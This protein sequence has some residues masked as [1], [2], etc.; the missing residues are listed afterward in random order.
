MATIATRITSSGTYFINGSFDEV[1][2]NRTSPVIKNL[3]ISTED[4]SQWANVGHVITTNQ[5]IAPDGSLTADRIQATTGSGGDY[6]AILNNSSVG[7]ASYT[8]SFWVKSVSGA[9]GTWGVNYY[10]GAHNRTTVP[11][12][13]EWT[14]QS[15]TFT[16]TGG[17]FNVYIADNRT[18][19]ATITDAYV[20]GAQLERGTVPTIYQGITSSG[21]LITPTFKNKVTSDAVY[22]TDIFDEVTFNPAT[23]G[24]Y[25]G[26]SLSYSQDMSQTSVWSYSSGGS[27]VPPVVTPN[28]ALAPDGTLTANRV[29]FNSGPVTGTGQSSLNQG[30]A[31]PLTT[32]TSQTF[33]VWMRVETTATLVNMYN[34]D[35]INSLSIDTNWTRYSLP[36]TYSSPVAY[37]VRIAKREIWG[38]GG[39]ANVLIWGAQMNPGL[40]AT[41]YVPT[42]A[43]ATPI[44]ISAKKETNEG[45][46][47]VT[48]NFN[49]VGGMITTNGLL[50]QLDP[51]KVE[52]FRNT[53]TS[54]ID[55]SGN[56]RNCSFI[57]EITYDSTSS[58]LLFDNPTITASN[59]ISLA[60]LE[61]IDNTI[62]FT[63]GSEYTIEFWCKIAGD[64]LVTYHSITGRGS[65]NPW[66]GIEKRA[67]DFRLFFRE[68]TSAAYYY[69]TGIPASVFTGWTQVVFSVNANRVVNYYV[70]HAAGTFTDF[71]TVTTSTFTINRLAAGYSSGGNFYAFD[72]NVGPINIYNKALSTDEVNNNF[73]ALRNR[74]GI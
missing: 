35:T 50:L 25:I 41:I 1:T 14:R 10:N 15:I 24:L 20:W 18:S 71:D 22:V 67:T 58:S 65:T 54:F 6:T 74:F 70:N 51:G 27:G 44:S 73:E 13:G 9:T 63:D 56:T 52:S 2:Y 47:Y 43:N 38:T 45:A 37:G 32:G 62:Y 34:G 49:E 12:T 4:F 31:V 40:T 28:A 21:I 60:S 39:A 55:I 57:G 16:G 72:G 61:G 68:I 26:N 59:R 69:S 36:I 30:N 64:A 33:S 17:Q 8:F 29:F 19:L 66:I 46:L 11:I 7:G 3:L 23:S 42:G 5:A 48:G 53:S